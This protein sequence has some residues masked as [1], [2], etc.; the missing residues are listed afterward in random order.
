M[1]TA[2][3]R[4]TSESGSSHAI[5]E[6][7]PQGRRGSTI[8]A[9]P[10]WELP[11]QSPESDGCTVNETRTGDSTTSECQPSIGRKPVVLV[12]MDFSPASHEAARFGTDIARRS[13]ALLLLVHA[14]HLNLSAYGPAN[15]AWLKA[16]LCQEA[17]AKAEPILT[18]AQGAGVLGLC[19]VEEGSPAAVIANVAKRWSAEIIILGARKRGILSRMFSPRTIEKVVEQ[20]KCPVIVVNTNHKNGIL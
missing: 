16:G 19:T 17:M 12:P 3:R 15:P 7:M 1:N 2:N 13:N 18:I 6:L 14:V 10:A 5:R 20:V 11:R 8:D 9:H 4:S